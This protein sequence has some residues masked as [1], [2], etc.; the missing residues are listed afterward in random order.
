MSRFWAASS[1]DDES[2]SEQSDSSEEPQNFKQTD[3][4]FAAA[5]DSS[6]SGMWR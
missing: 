3:K 1:S 4:K 5:F 2:V 6:D